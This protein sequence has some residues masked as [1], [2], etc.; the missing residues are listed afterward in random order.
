MGP[1]LADQI[2]QNLDD[3]PLKNIV[4]EPSAMCFS[5]VDSNYVFKVI[6][7]LKNGKAPGPDEIPIMVP[8]P[9]VCDNLN[10]RI[11]MT[12]KRVY[13]ILEFSNIDD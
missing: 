11:R 12:T 13:I 10:C 6:Q 7:Q 8:L 9:A 1:K 3:D 2:E 5:P 4:N